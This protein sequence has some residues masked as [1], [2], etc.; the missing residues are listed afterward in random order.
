MN[1]HHSSGL[2]CC[3]ILSLLLLSSS[4]N[5]FNTF[6]NR[7]I[8][9][10]FISPLFKKGVADFYWQSATMFTGN[11]AKK[12]KKKPFCSCDHLDLPLLPPWWLVNVSH[13]FTVLSSQHRQC[14]RDN[15]AGMW[16]YRLLFMHEFARFASVYTLTQI[17]LCVKQSIYILKVKLSVI[18]RY[19]KSTL[20]WWSTL[21]PSW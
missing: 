21:L 17:K 16:N 11:F 2:N 10:V 4:P 14:C 18:S 12:K 1:W 7:I 19:K 9:T 6:N 3:Y 20:K 15:S 5:S 13:H 8:P